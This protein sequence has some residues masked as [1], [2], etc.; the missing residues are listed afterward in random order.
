MGA[1]VASEVLAP[2]GRFAPPLTNPG[3]YA[4]ILTALVFRWTKSFLGATIVGMASYVVLR[5]LI[6]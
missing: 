3:I 6:A 1:L 5:G 4:A 2:H